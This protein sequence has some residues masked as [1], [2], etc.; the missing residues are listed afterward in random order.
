MLDNALADIKCPGCGEKME[1]VTG[2]Y[3]TNWESQYW[4]CQQ[5]HISVPL[6]EPERSICYDF[7]NFYLQ[8]LS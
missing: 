7:I 5:C 4:S 1:L 3:V 2:G 6:N 8:L